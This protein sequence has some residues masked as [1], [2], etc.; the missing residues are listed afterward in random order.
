M[1]FSLTSRLGGVKQRELN[2][3]IDTIMEFLYFIPPN[4]DVELNINISEVV[5][6]DGC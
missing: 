3:R 6:G 1:S 5:H 4:L 2:K